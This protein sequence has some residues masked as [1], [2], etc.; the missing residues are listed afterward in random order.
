VHRELCNNIADVMLVWG[1]AEQAL[2]LADEAL[3]LSPNWAR[4]AFRV[5]LHGMKVQAHWQRGELGAALGHAEGA[6][7]MALEDPSVNPLADCVSMA[8]DV[9]AFIGDWAGAD[10]LLAPL[11][12]RMAE[13]S[14]HFAVKLAFNRVRLALQRGDIDAARQALSAVGPVA[15]LHERRDQEHAVLCQAEFALATGDADAAARW[16]ADWPAP[17]AHVEVAARRALAALQAAQ[18]L[19]A[20]RGGR[21]KPATAAPPAAL[22]AALP[23]AVA[24]ARAQAENPRAPLPTRLELSRALANQASTVDGTCPAQGPTQRPPDWPATASRLLDAMGVSLN[25]R[26][27][28]QA[29]LLRRW[30]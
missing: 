28:Q 17:E 26:P 15:E 9:Y 11:Q 5:Y 30:G 27:M 10:A 29:A 12:A 25:D 18:T 16:L 13:V 3:G 4:P 2:A 20:G 6:L 21:P 1:E 24:T 8:L 14:P 7:A 22:P 19:A 23:S